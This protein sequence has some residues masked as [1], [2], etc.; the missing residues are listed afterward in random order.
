MRRRR[1]TATA[2]DVYAKV[3][4]E[5][6]DLCGEG[7]RRLVIMHL[8]VFH[9]RQAGVWQNRDGQRSILAKVTNA[10]SHVTRPGTAVHANH[11]DRKRRQGGK[12]GA[13]LS[14]VEHRPKHFD[15][16]LS[17]HRQSYAMLLEVSE[18]CG[19]RGLGLQKILTGFDNQQIGAAVDE[20]PHL[21][22]ICCFQIEKTYMAQRR[23]LASRPH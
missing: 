20:S 6:D 19:Q 4:G 11:V 2:D 1:A 8:A 9:R 14:A 23:Q 18:D 10:L 21:F 17:N 5:V 12:R 15:R 13:N 7:F 16:N 3:S 22:R